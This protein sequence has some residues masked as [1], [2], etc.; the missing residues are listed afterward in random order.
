MK[1][2]KIVLGVI[3][4]VILIGAI[5]VGIDQAFKICEAVNDQLFTLFIFLV[6]CV[7]VLCLA[8]AIMYVISK[9]KIDEL[10]WE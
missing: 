1:I 7:Y 5:V 8:T 3:A 9:A 6:G 2:A 10:M 4:I